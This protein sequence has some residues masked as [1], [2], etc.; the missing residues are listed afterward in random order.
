MCFDVALDCRIEGRGSANVG[1]VVEKVVWEGVQFGIQS[2]S[3]LKVA[4]R[5]GKLDAW[6]RAGEDAAWVGEW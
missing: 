2:R 6:D 5:V 4:A 1:V 3:T